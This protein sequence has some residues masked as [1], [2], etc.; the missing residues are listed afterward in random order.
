VIP[1]VKKMELIQLYSNHFMKMTRKFYQGNSMKL[2]KG[3]D[4]YKWS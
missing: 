3:M 1:N 4:S 2:R